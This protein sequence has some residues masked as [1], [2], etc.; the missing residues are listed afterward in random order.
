MIGD[1]RSLVLG[2]MEPKHAVYFSGIV[3]TGMLFEP[4]EQIAIYTDYST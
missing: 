1:T 2:D 3:A 4:L